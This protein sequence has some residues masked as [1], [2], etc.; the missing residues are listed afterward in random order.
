MGY[1]AFAVRRTLLKSRV[2]KIE[3]CFTIS[4]VVVCSETIQWTSV[5]TDKRKLY[6]QR[7]TLRR[8]YT[9]YKKWA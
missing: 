8:T 4:L 9:N 1:V 5:N 3:Q 7:G 2:E 6:A